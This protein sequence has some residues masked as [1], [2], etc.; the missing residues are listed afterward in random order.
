MSRSAAVHVR[1]NINVSFFFS[2]LLIQV[3]KLFNENYTQIPANLEEKSFKPGY[4]HKLKT[5]LNYKTVILKKLQ[6]IWM[7]LKRSNH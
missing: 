7:A 1:F 6:P 4:L 3:G 5:D 2:C